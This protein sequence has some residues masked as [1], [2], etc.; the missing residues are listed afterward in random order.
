ME[1]TRRYWATVALAA[2]L[3]AFAVVSGRVWPLVGG[4]LVGAWVLAQQ[5]SFAV[6]VGRFD[7]RLDVEQSIGRREVATEASAEVSLVATADRPS[8]LDARVSA[9]PPVTV[10]AGPERVAR[11]PA[12]STRAETA[13]EA[14]FPVA[15][16]ATFDPPTITAT[17]PAGL[18][19]TSF[20]AGEAV[21]VDVSARTPSE[22]RVGRGGSTI[23]VAYGEHPGVRSTAGTEPVSVRDYVPGDAARRIDWKS[24]ARL[25][26]LQ[27]REFESETTLTT[28][29]LVDHGS[30]TGEGLTG[31]TKLDYLR[32]VASSV[33][34]YAARADDP[35]GCYTVDDRGITSRLSP[36]TSRDYAET[37][38][39]RLDEL[40][41]AIDS[42]A[43]AVGVR[44][45]SVR[46]VPVLDG[47]F[48][49]TVE[50]YL[51]AAGTVETADRP[52][53]A[54][55]QTI[56]S[57]L[58]SGRVFVFTDDTDRAAVIDAVRA[59]VGGGIEVVVILAPTVLFE[60]RTM[61]QLDATH[62]EYVAFERFRRELA[63]LHDVSAFEVAPGDRV[64]AVLS[65]GTGLR[66]ASDA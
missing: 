7:D 4:G 35:I 26:E 37:V 27:V 53:V 17:D 3:A 54:A 1:F 55:A 58:A 34:E 14:E 57:R 32:A 31:E 9:T 48:G 63:G 2:V 65:A 29:L 50:A 6:A 23:G 28:V 44:P 39:R 40:A 33:V 43:S 51:D 19:R 25:H 24:T 11:L 13:F 60:R 5:L 52:L 18:F 46:R 49:R 47:A 41:A 59:L 16:R 20:A 56:R 8:R 45:L 36:G 66:R 62:R 21:T 38:E 10:D 22:V 12:G 61:A 64:D 42:S 30:S 15:G